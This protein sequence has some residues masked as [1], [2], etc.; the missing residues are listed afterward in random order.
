MKRY[1]LLEDDYARADRAALTVAPLFN[2][3]GWTWREGDLD[4][5]PNHRQIGDTIEGLIERCMESENI[6]ETGRLGVAPDSELGYRIYLCL[7]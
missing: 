6:H 4:Y 5:I 3:F 7:S 1:D 2:I